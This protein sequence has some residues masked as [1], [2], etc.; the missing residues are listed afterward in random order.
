MKKQVT[1]EVR[2]IMVNSLALS[3]LNYCPNIWG[4]ACKSQIQ[5]IQKLQNLAAKVAVG[6]GK[7]YDHATPFIQ[8]LE[9]LK[10]DKKCLVDTCI[11]TYKCLNKLLPEWLITFTMVSA[12]NPI[13]TRQSGNLV[14]PRTH[15]NAGERGIKV[16]GP[17][18]W[19]KLP[20]DIQN[21][22]TLDLFKRKVKSFYLRAQ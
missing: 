2:V 22:P 5:R 15:T 9:W 6:N 16:R 19:N 1:P 11:L 13:S 12:I 17:K 18:L 10:I 4:T 14:V 20:L 3:Y 21:S 8:K 7:K